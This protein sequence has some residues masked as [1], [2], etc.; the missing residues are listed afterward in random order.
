MGHEVDKEQRAKLFPTEES[1]FHIV[2]IFQ[3][4][5]ILLECVHKALADYKRARKRRKRRKM[6]I[7]LDMTACC[8]LPL[9]SREGC[10]LKSKRHRRCEGKTAE[11]MRTDRCNK[12][13]V[14]E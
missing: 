6:F 13:R 5:K 1:A 2:R 9:Q 8:A 3:C 11:T 12:I 10:N 4:S 7:T 14:V